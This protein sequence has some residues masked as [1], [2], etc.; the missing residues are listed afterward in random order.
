M[1]FGMNGEWFKNFTSLINKDQRPLDDKYWNRGAEV[2][3]QMRTDATQRKIA[4]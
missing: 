1:I 3:R 2:A 4:K